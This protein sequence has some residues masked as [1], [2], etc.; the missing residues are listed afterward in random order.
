MLQRRDFSVTI[1]YYAT[2]TDE[3]DLVVPCWQLL[4]GKKP[5]IRSELCFD[6]IPGVC[7]GCRFP[8]LEFSY[9]I[10]T[11][12]WKNLIRAYDFH[13]AVGGTVLV[14]NTLAMTGV[15]HLVWCAS[16][17]L[18]DRIDRRAKMPVGR[19]ILDRAV[20]GPFQRNLE[21]RILRGC[22]QFMAL[23]NYT[24]TT[25]IAA[26]ARPEAIDHVP[27]P[28]N[29]ANYTPSALPPREALIGFAGRIDDPRKNISLLLR[30]V[31]V[32]AGRGVPI[33]L[34]LTGDPSVGLDEL[35]SSLNIADRLEWSG[36]LDPSSLP[37]FYRSLDV[38]VFSSGQ[39]GL[40]ISGIQAMACGV[41]V[42]STKCGGPEDYVI[43]GVTGKLCGH[44]PEALADAIYWA[45]SDRERRNDLGS[46]SRRLIENDYSQ[47][48]FEDNVARVWEKTWGEFPW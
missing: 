15:P 25:L 20:I 47:L 39:E 41:P 28:V 1:A 24:R 46:K 23:S 21:K 44:T 38:F 37:D 18:E 19:R 35:A 32:L 27:M 17:M 13:I 4:S 11:T 2:L 48:V 34:K 16:T 26:G 8:E 43:D 31:A 5:G 42:V 6:D 22:G 10:T 12:R 3:P 7:V 29:V 45:I 33:R 36:W 9:Y 14:A 40:G 30:S